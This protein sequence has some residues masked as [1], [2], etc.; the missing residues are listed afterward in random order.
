MT[1]LVYI[2]VFPFTQTAKGLRFLLL[3]RSRDNSYPGIWQ[4]VAGKIK[5]G[6]K[7]WEAGLRELKEETGFSPFQFYALDHVSTYY[8]H[9]S[10]DVIHVPA[11]MAE[12][13]DTA[14]DLSHEHD[15][16]KWC[17]LEEALRTASWG[18]YRQ[19]LEAI[20]QLLL[21][22]PALKLAKIHCHLS[23]R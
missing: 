16:F 3:R 8:L 18:P 20:P 4:P 5:T 13:P 17:D 10:D 14:P 12:V 2:D 19:A 1:D 11:F 15:C 21:S 22:A 7:A 23:S 6:E 9:A